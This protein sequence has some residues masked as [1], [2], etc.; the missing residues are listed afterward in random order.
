MGLVM[1]DCL[2]WPFLLLIGLVV[3]FLLRDKDH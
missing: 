1:P 3:W 2:V